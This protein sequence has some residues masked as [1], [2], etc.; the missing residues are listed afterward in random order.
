MCSACYSSLGS[1]YYPRM[2]LLFSRS[3]CESSSLF[4]LDALRSFSTHSL[5][6]SWE[7]LRNF[8]SESDSS[9][10]ANCIGI[11]PGGLS[12][13]LPAQPHIPPL[14]HSHASPRYSYT[15]RR[16]VTNPLPVGTRSE[17]ETPQDTPVR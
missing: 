17:A 3:V 2:P 4:P 11:K 15:A 14:I 9:G 16:A 13:S 5:G 10:Q 7:S 1:Q 8:P 6:S 12:E